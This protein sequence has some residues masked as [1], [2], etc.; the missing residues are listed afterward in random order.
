[1][2]SL[3]MRVFNSPDS[4]GISY[5]ARTQTTVRMTACHRMHDLRHASLCSGGKD[6]AGILRVCALPVVPGTDTSPL[7]Y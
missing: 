3:L 1:M 5:T 7:H 6:R 2:G 4:N